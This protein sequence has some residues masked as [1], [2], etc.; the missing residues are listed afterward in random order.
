M[1]AL[2]RPRRRAPDDEGDEF[3]VQLAPLVD[4]VF[5]LLIFF[6]V[7]T[8]YMDEEKDLSVVLPKVS[9]EKGSSKPRLERVLLNVREDGTVLFG[10]RP[11]GRNDLYRALVEARRANPHIPV[12]LR[13]DRAASH[14]EIVSVLE[15]CRRARIR[16]VA[17][18]V[19]KE[20]KSGA[21]P[22]RATTPEEPGATREK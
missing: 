15:L 8:T 20:P 3:G 22:R 5:L 21:R 4:I 18:A 10:T 19:E 11:L 7:A 9:A 6:L 16:N 14:G 2:P 17:I 1:R 13:G 12:I